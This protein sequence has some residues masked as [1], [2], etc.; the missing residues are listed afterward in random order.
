MILLNVS[1][2]RAESRIKCRG[3][4]ALLIA[5]LCIQEAEQL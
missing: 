1:H 3:S 2:F 5:D 4:H